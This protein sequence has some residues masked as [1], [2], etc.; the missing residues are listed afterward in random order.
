MLI[1]IENNLDK[2]SQNS[3]LSSNV[4]AGTVILPIKNISNFQSS[5]AVQVGKTG[6]EQTEIKILSAGAISGTSLTTTVNTTYPHPQDT[7]VYNVHYDSIIVKRSTSGTAGTATAITSGTISITPDSYY[8]EYNDSAGA[9]SYAYKTQFYNSFNGDLSSDSDWLVPGGPTFY[10]KAKLRSRVKDA[11]FNSGFIGDDSIIDDWVNEALEEMN[12]AA[13]K[14]NK[15]YLLGTTSIAF[16]T[17]GLGTVTASDFMYPRKIEVTY[18]GNSYTPTIN[19]ALNEYDEVTRF[20]GYNPRH[21]WQGDNVFQILP[22]GDAGTARMIYSKGEALLDNE[23]D[24]LPFPMRRYT[25]FFVEYG[26]YRAQG[27][28]QKESSENS[29][30]SRAKSIKADFINEITPRDQTGP[31]YMSF[32]NELNA[33]DDYDVYI[34]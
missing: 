2:L 19:I 18:D 30:Y 9:A 32:V 34:Y 33:N 16:G 15:D 22:K 25:R 13:V 26:L 6:E 7:P 1:K 21:S 23:T 8:T 20:T 31:Q 3:F 24:E 11:L 17:A 29:H 27:K 12:T 5:W 10:S 4:T 14:V 28:D